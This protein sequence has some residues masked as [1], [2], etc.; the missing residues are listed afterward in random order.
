[1]CVLAPYYIIIIHLHPKQTLTISI[2]YKEN[3]AVHYT[4]IILG[5]K[6]NIII[7]FMC[8]HLLNLKNKIQL[9][10]QRPQINKFK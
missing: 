7:Y 3:K 5:Q 8:V 1:M 10:R 4:F 6:M 9:L 2:P